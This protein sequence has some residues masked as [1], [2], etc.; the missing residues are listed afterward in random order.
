MS[1]LASIRGIFDCCVAPGKAYLIPALHRH[2]AVNS[3]W[4]FLEGRGSLLTVKW[5]FL[6]IKSESRKHSAHWKYYQAKWGL[7]CGQQVN[8]DLLCVFCGSCSC[9]PSGLILERQ[10]VVSHSEVMGTFCSCPFPK[11]SVSLGFLPGC[12]LFLLPAFQT[13]SWGMGGS[14]LCSCQWVEDDTAWDIQL[15]WGHWERAA[16]QIFPAWIPKNPYFCLS[17]PIIK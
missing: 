10:K 3:S 4:R 2:L 14:T 17:K 7:C 8:V 13:S 11:E 9:D 1:Q 16:C 12:S 15:S 5:G 6:G